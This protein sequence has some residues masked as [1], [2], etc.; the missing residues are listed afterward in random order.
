MLADH[1]EDAPTIPYEQSP[2]CPV[3]FASDTDSWASRLQAEFASMKPWYDIGLKRRNHRTLVGVSQTSV[4]EIVQRLAA[5]L[6]AETLPADLI[7]FKS[8]IEDLKAFYI[9]A[10]TAAPGNY[11]SEDTYNALWHDTQFGAGLRWFHDKFADHPKLSTF[12]RIVLP[13]NAINN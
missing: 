7:W 5:D 9:E 10:M 4:E 6:D 8:A 11:S 13:R 3:T 12:A 2:A 1:E